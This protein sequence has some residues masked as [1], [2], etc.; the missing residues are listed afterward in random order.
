MYIAIVLVYYVNCWL[1][2]A[3]KT[4]R[5]RRVVSVE[6]TVRAK[7]SRDVGSSIPVHTDDDVEDS[8]VIEVSDEQTQENNELEMRIITDK[9]TTK[10]KSRLSEIDSGILMEE[11]EDDS[12]VGQASVR[13]VSSHGV[14]VKQETSATRACLSQTKSHSSNSDG[15]TSMKQDTSHKFVTSGSEGNVETLQVKSPDSRAQTTSDSPMETTSDALMNFAP[16]FDDTYEKQLSNADDHS[17]FLRKEVKPLQSKKKRARRE[18]D[19]PRDCAPRFSGRHVVNDS[20]TDNVDGHHSA[21]DD[22]IVIDS[23]NTDEQA[24]AINHLA[25]SNSH[26][27][28]GIFVFLHVHEFLL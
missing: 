1:I 14:N 21:N 28:T 26:T 6:S 9:K 27:D 13:K 18:V 23:S 11:E 15:Q 22:L 19:K 8:C 17:E 5:K 25:L 3:Q 2:C 4:G 20:E 12:A 10:N 24:S 7:K 16:E